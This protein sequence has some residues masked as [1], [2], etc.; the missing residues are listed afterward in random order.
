M[1]KIN[2]KSDFDFIL[3]L[4][5]CRGED[6]GVPDFD[7]TAR[8]YT[9]A[10]A[11]AFVASCREGVY[12]NCF[13]DNGQLHIVCDG[14]GLPSGTLL[15]E[16]TAEL[17]NGIYPDGSERIVSPQAIGIELVRGKGDCSTE[18]EAELLLPMLK[19]DPFTFEDF[20]PEQLESLRGPKGDKGDPGEQGIQGVQGEKGDAGVQGPV[21]PQGI[22]GEDG[23]SAYEQAVEGGYKGAE[24]E[25][26]ESLSEIDEMARHEPTD[27]SLEAIEPNIVA[28][29]L[30]KTEQALSPAEQAQVLRN[31]GNPELKVFI[32]Q[33]NATVR[34][35][36][37]Y[38]PHTGLF[39]LNGLDDITN[40]E[41]YEILAD[42][43]VYTS[44]CYGLYYNKGIRTRTLI[45]T[46]ATYHTLFGGTCE[47]MFARC[48]TLEVVRLASGNANEI[49]PTSI[50]SMFYYC[51]RL[52]EILGIIDLASCPSSTNFVF[53]GCTSLETVY[54]K[55]IKSDI[56]FEVSPKLSL[57]SVRFLV[58][59]AANTNSIAI[60]VHPTVYAKLTDEANEEWNSLLA[61]AATKNIQFA[62]V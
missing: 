58:E 55:N 4:T 39:S 24:D 54:L 2:Y 51:T 45:P 52:R 22:Q 34:E 8:F 47:Y 46:I 3:R 60:T 27:A 18:A 13:D 6:V 20:T 48:G 37:G 5:D 59:N 16:F 9:A 56:L 7:W 12:S 49:I 25:F 11:D 23:A 30:R 14:H 19:G 43:V 42:S 15:C 38:N 36:G 62:T 32:D 44:S 50:K 1:R 33:W 28:D 35:W 41:A 61:L 21:G 53:Y 29:A 26:M 40:E 57:S 17:P 31:L 10:S